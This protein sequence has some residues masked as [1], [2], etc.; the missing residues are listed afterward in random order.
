MARVRQTVKIGGRE[1]DLLFTP[2]IY[3]VARKKGVKIEV[4]DVDNLAEVL[5]IYTKLFYL[6]ALNAL[7]AK[8]FDNPSEPDLGIGYIDFAEW[9]A[10]NSEA[11]MSL[12]DT[13]IEALTGKPLKEVLADGKGSKKKEEE[14]DR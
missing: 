10:E 14:N 4:S 9:A 2:S 12:I 6:A 11:F 1:I 7:E 13:A 5:E 3:A 8:R